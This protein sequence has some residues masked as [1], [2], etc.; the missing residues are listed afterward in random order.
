MK[1]I[2]CLDDKGGMLFNGRRQSRDS[3]LISH[4]LALTG[5]RRLYMNE[6]SARLFG[7]DIRRKAKNVTVDD[8]FLFFAGEED[9]CFVENED[10]SDFL[11]VID[12]VI[13]YRWGRVYPSDV[14]FPVSMFAP[15]WRLTH[16]EE[17]PGTSHEKI[18][19]SRY[20]L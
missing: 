13:I 8:A 6:Y 14:R 17:F 15:R 7:E 5:G 12:E 3:A 19:V 10:V 2:V 11:D 1:I 18:T 20:S 16:T 9:Y 4:M